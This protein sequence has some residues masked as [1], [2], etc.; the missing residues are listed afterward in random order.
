MFASRWTRL[1]WAVLVVVL[2][3]AATVAIADE[4]APVKIGVPAN[5]FRDIPKITIDALMPTFTRLMEAQTGV[6]GQI[7][8]LKN[9][10]EVAK[11]LEDN[12]IQFAVFHGFE[13]AWAQTK[14]KDLR[15]LVVAISNQSPNL[16][17]QVV[18]ASDSS[19]AKLDDLQ[20][21][22]V[23][24]PRGTREHC[25]LFLSRRLNGI[26]HRQ[27]KFFGGETT[28]PNVAAALDDV[29]SGKVQA[30]VVEGA[31]WDNYKWLNPGKA[32]RLKSLMKSE[33]FPTGVIA[34]KHGNVPDANLTKFRDGLTSA[35]QKPEGLQL[36][37]LWKL[38][39]FDVVP[40]DYHQL[41]AD[42]VR[43]YPPPIGDE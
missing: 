7:V 20:G 18:V 35:H 6:R 10:G 4:N 1:R 17:A 42:I 24:I 29:M 16:T 38:N 41:L 21:H 30:T 40:A 8:L 19:F 26:G 33:T 25:R 27:E 2:A 39:R 28:P 3:P 12:R 9:G 14:H 31:A 22:K 37:M 15:P 32:N 13:F 34:Y 5:L 43:A 36:I 11:Q 23:A